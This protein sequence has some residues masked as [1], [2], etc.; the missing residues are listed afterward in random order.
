[1][2]SKTSR[3]GHKLRSRTQAATKLGVKHRVP[4]KSQ[5]VNI[6]LGFKTTHAA[7]KLRAQHQAPII[8]KWQKVMQGDNQ[9]TKSQV[10]SDWGKPA[11]LSRHQHHS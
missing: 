8:H 5:W 6:M 9:T 3:E 11:Y 4:A 2:G 7:T 1:M 10:D